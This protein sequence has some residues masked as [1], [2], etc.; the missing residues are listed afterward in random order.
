MNVLSQGSNLTWPC[1]QQLSMERHGAWQILQSC[2]LPLSPNLGCSGSLSMAPQSCGSSQPHLWLLSPQ[3]CTALARQSYPA[4]QALGQPRCV[5]CGCATLSVFYPYKHTSMAHVHGPCVPLDP[6][7]EWRIRP[8]K[9]T[10]A[11][12]IIL[13]LEG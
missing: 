3:C 11:Y 4:R 9:N 12:C 8:C 13:S 7:K 6:I 10:Q 5:L 2:H 1:W